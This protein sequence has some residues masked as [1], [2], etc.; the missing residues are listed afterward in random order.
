MHVVRLQAPLGLVEFE[1]VLV[2][3]DQ[4]LRIKVECLG[5]YEM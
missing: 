4:V 5:T 1:S 2:Y 3:D